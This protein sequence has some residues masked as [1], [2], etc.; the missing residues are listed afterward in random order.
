MFID[1]FKLR[2]KHHAY[3][4][5]ARKEVILLPLKC[6]VGQIVCYVGNNGK[7]R[8]IS[9]KDCSALHILCSLTSHEE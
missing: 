8:Q 9:L 2:M 7:I 6:I 5:D 1:T 4:R 3:K